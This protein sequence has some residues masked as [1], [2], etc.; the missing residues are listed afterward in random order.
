VKPTMK[1]PMKPNGFTL[2]ELLVVIA[3]IGI[4]AATIIPRFTGRTQEARLNAAK[5][6][7]RAMSTALDMYESDSG[8]FPSTI[9]GLQAL[10][11]KPTG[12]PDPTNWKGPYLKRDQALVDPWGSPYIYLAPGNYN[13]ESYDLLS[14]GPD[15]KEGT[16]DDINNW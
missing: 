13:P 1:P 9:Q 15:I 7:V 14:V 12:D 3:I 5:T 2:V 11:E 8:I 6:D 4:L 16:G 10:I